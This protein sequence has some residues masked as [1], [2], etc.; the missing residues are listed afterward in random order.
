MRPGN[1]KYRIRRSLITYIA[2]DPNA[3]VI[4]PVTDIKE[5][6]WKSGKS[7]EILIRSINEGQSKK[8][9]KQPIFFIA[10]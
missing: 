6:C 1:L 7:D 2:L 9:M 8:I 3:P 10:D 5:F 4:T